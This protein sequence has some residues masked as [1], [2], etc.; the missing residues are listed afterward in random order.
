MKKITSLTLCLV[1]L[2]SLCAC[3]SP[4]F[5]AETYPKMG[6]SLA[7]LPLGEALTAH[8]LDTDRNT[9]SSLLT[10]EGSTTDNYNALVD[11][12]FDIILAYEPSEQAKAYAEEKGVTWEMTPIGIDA[13]VFITG[14]NNPTENLTTEQI[15]A[16]YNGEITNWA[17][18]GGPDK[19]IAA[20]VRNTDSGSHTLFDLFFDLKNY[21][22][23]QREYIIG[24][25]VG[26][27]DAIASYQGTDEALGY[28]VYYY[29]TNMESATLETSKLLA[30]NDVMPS[31][32]T[33]AS[34]EYP[35]SNEFY[36]VIRSDTPQNSQT[37]ILY[38]WICSA[39]GREIA[40]SE[41]YVVPKQ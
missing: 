12:T 38:D 24:S 33:I 32:D 27:L 37:R 2:L 30:V 23:I 41:N 18:V 28:T 8:A 16:I 21:D 7:A 14:K 10:F 25:M 31:N 4:S 26:L 5:T 3:K 34:G 29:L 22:S 1:L 11:G 20:Y 9:A 17:E 35:L 36:A 39:Q 6:G 19:N 13:L 15:S 40:E